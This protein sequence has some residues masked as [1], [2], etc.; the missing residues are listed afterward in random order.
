M[1]QVLKAKLSQIP[2]AAVVF[3]RGGEGRREEELTSPEDSFFDPY[4]EW[5]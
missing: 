5:G 2:A 1:K 3:N 4:I